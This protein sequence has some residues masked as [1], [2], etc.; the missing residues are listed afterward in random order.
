MSTRRQIAEAMLDHKVTQDEMEILNLIRRNYRFY[1]DFL[2]CA[3]S[4]GVISGDECAL[5]NTIKQ[6]VYQSTL[7]TALKDGQIM[8]DEERLLGKFRE[9][10]NI[11]VNQGQSTSL[12]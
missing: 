9:H 12:R 5:S 11:E 10:V 1:L 2:R 3:M 4:D 8:E 7:D 6:S